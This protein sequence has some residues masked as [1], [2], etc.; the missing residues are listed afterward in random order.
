MSGGQNSFLTG[1][2]MVCS[3]LPTVHH[4]I[5]KIITPDPI[6][7]Q[8]NPFLYHYTPF[9]ITFIISSYLFLLLFFFD[10]YAY[11]IWRMGGGGATALSPSPAAATASQFCYQ[12]AYKNGMKMWTQ[13]ELHEESRHLNGCQ[14]SFPRFNCSN[15]EVLAA[16]Y[17]DNV[18][19]RN[20]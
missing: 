18:A 14:S 13:N 3:P 17:V 9:I 1:T 11:V 5:H 4:H 8:L 6:L 19:W 15:Y 20:N 2:V 16:L 10:L 7:S 12:A